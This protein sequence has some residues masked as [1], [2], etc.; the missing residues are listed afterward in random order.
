LEEFAGRAVEALRNVDDPAVGV[1][2]RA[3]VEDRMG[4]NAASS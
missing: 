3:F 1:D 2:G 4:R